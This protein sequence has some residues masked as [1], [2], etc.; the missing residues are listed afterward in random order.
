MAYPNDVKPQFYEEKVL[1]SPISLSKMWSTKRAKIGHLSRKK[2]PFGVKYFGE[3]TFVL[4]LASR[5]FFRKVIKSDQKWDLK[6][7]PPN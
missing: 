6:L 5:S 2:Y 1:K 7:G 3:Y 4:A